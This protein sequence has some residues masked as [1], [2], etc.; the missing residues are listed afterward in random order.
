MDPQILYNCSYI[1]LAAGIIL[2]I[3]TIVLFFKF[4]MI[5]IIRSEIAERRKADE[6][7]GDSYYNRVVGLIHDEED[8]EEDIAP[9]EKAAEEPS[10]P[11]K[12]RTATVQK[13]RKKKPVSKKVQEQPEPPETPDESTDMDDTDVSITVL[14]SGSKKESTDGETVV[15]AKNKKPDLDDD[16]YRII[17]SIIVIHGDPH[18][19]K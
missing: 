19:I 4:G 3:L 12:P 2:L 18:A 16:D 8:T 15:T 1:L 13:P 7:D 11:K 5:G 10:V 17:D 14:V 6:S 9:E